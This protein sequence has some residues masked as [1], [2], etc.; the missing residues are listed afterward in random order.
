MLLAVLKDYVKLSK[1]SYF[2]MRDI[3]LKKYDHVYELLNKI[4]DT[5]II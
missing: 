4:K 3:M 2:V 1:K 5:F